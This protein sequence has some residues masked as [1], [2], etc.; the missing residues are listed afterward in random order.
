MSG[1]FGHGP[2][3]IITRADEWPKPA[4]RSPAL[5]EF[6]RPDLNAH[7]SPALNEL[8]RPALGED[9]PP[10]GQCADSPVQAV[11]TSRPAEAVS[12]PASGSPN[13]SSR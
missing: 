1:H 3:P 11:A 5:N 4:H 10:D 12:Q 13:F 6:G 2:L 8:G 7:R 9:R